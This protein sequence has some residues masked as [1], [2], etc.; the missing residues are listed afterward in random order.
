MSLAGRDRKSRGERGVWIDGPR[1][2]VW[3]FEF[4]ESMH[5]VEEELYD[6]SDSMAR[7]PSKVER[8][9]RRII[10]IEAPRAFDAYH[11]LAFILWYGYHDPKEAIAILKTG[12]SRAEEIFPERFELG[13]SHLPWG[14]LEN[15]PFLR[16]YESLGSR[17]FE[18]GK[19]EQ[20]TKV[21]EDM[22]TMNPDDN[23]GVRETLCECYFA[24][25]DPDSVLK[26]CEM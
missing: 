5:D 12:L 25:D 4:S 13:K 21:F 15:R 17:Y 16:M 10:E 7:S 6:L 14:V 23:Q 20:A 18:L 3:S 9:L 2:G 22:V 1:E 26:L 24:R 11:Q 8:R 19:L